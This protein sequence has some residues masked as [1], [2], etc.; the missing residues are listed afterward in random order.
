VAGVS[1]LLL[2]IVPFVPFV[3]IVKASSGPR[4]IVGCRNKLNRDELKPGV[5][6]TLDMTTL[7]IMRKLP[8]E[9]D[10]VVYHMMTEDPGEV[11]YNSIGGLS[12]QIRELREV[13]RPQ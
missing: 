4:Y 13:R 10:P 11:A 12:E 6:V 8:R 3:V 5:R 1:D 7:T 2:V 9:V